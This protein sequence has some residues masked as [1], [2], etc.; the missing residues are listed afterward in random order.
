MPM[1]KLHQALGALSEDLTAG[2]WAPHPAESQLASYVAFGLQ[3]IAAGHRD[4][5]VANRAATK[6]L[7]QIIRAALREVGPDVATP[8]VTDT[9]WATV[10]VH[11]AAA[12]EPVR[13]A[14]SEDGQRLAV[15]L[16][17]TC[18]DVA[19]TLQEQP[20]PMC[21]RLALGW[22]AVLG[23]DPLSAVSRSSARTLY[24]LHVQNTHPD[25]PAPNPDYECADCRHFVNYV[26]RS[27][28]DVE[29]DGA[30]ETSGPEILEQH[31]YSHLI[32]RVPVPRPAEPMAA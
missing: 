29:V 28:D 20:C 9:R 10:V 19:A 25:T 4:A 22:H 27:G 6:A 3:S 26:E 15:E 1:E 24:G 17:N 18:V 21:F 31:L 12:V 13:I 8:S 5:S 11:C 32:E 2:R 16:L 30:C 14:E 23:T 7:T